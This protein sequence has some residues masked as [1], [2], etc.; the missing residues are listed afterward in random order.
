MLEF[1]EGALIVSLG[2]VNAVLE[3]GEDFAVV[4]IDGAS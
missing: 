1:L 3:T 2:G 4:V